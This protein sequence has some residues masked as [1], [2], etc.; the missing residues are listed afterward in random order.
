MR[1]GGVRGKQVGWIDF[2]PRPL[3]Y[4]SSRFW[5]SPLR[6][7]EKYATPQP[8]TSAAGEQILVDCLVLTFWLQPG[9]KPSMKSQAASNHL[10]HGPN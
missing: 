10:C 6:H 7:A 4:S 1:S 3:C 9:E 5:L 8:I 2:S